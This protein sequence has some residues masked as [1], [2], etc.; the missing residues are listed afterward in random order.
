MTE[1]T[2]APVA[3]HRF[4]SS[5]TKLILVARKAFAAF[6][7]SSALSAAITSSGASSGW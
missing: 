7:T 3:S 6:L 2:D 5:L 4:A 1:S